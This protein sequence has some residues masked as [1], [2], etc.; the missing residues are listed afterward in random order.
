MAKVRAFRKGFYIGLRTPGTESEVFDH[1]NPKEIANWA[2]PVGEE[3][4]PDAEV[5]TAAQ[6]VRRSAKRGAAADPLV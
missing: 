2:E 5:D 4:K 1:P 6:P 3:I